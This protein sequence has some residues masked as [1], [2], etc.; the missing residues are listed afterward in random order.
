MAY[1]LANTQVCHLS[2][3]CLVAGRHAQRGYH[4]ECPCCDVHSGKVPDGDAKLVS[5]YLRNGNAEVAAD[6]VPTAA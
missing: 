1:H 4:A 3:V 6:E 2:N 5:A